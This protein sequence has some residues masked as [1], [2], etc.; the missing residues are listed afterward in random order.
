VTAPTGA[1][2][3]PADA[4][5]PELRRE[6]ASIRAE[7]ERRFDDGEAAAVLVPELARRIDRILIG[8]W[9]LHG[10]GDGAALVAVGGYGRGELHPW[11]DID[12]L[13][14]TRAD[15][16]RAVLDRVQAFI[17]GLWDLRLEVGH[18]VRSP[19]QCAEQARADVTVATAMMESRLLA[20]S[21]KLFEQMC[22][23]ATGSAVWNSRDFLEAKL[24]EQRE[25][26]RRFD[27]TAYKVE[28]NVK[29]SPGGMRD[30]QIVAWVA[31]HHFGVSRLEDLVSR[32]FLTVGE[33][34]ALIAGRDF[35][36]Q[37]R[38]ALHVDAGRREDRLLFEHQRAL[39]SRFG[40]RDDDANLAVEQFMRRYYRTVMELSRLIEMLMELLLEAILVT[41]GETAPAI[42]NRRF[43]SVSGFLE[44]RDDAVFARQPWA[45]LELF[46]VLQQNPQLKGVRASTIRLVRDH[47]HLIDDSFR[48]DIR[49]RSLFL[50]IL[51]QPRGVTHELE[52][53]HRYGVL[54]AYLP[55]FD[56]VSGRM[57]FDLFHMY[58]V[59]EHSLR[60]VGKLRAFA[61]PAK[62]HEHPLC[63][64]IFERL[65]KPELLYI[66]G[67]FHDLAKGRGGDHSELGAGDVLAFCTDHGL[68]QYDARLAAWLVRHHLLMST[69][70]QRRD[71]TDP[72][73]V[74]EFALEVADQ[75]HL[76]YLYLLT[77]GDIRGTNPKLWNDWRASLLRDLYVATSRALRAGLEN[78]LERTQ[79]IAETQAQAELV[80]K[81]LDPT[82]PER[83]ASLWTTLGDDYFLRSSP[84]EVAWH[85]R[86]IVEAGEQGLPLVLARAGRGG[87][88]IFVYARD[89]EFLFAATCS[90]LDRLGLSI[91][92]SRII[93]ADNAMTLDSYV[94]LDLE[95]EPVREPGRL[96]AI[97]HALHQ[98]LTAPAQA[99]GETRRLL[100]RQLK[101]FSTPTDVLFSEDPRNRRTVLD[102]ITADRPG[103]L[104]RIGWTL[105]DHGV[106]LQNAK[107]STFGERAEDV[108]FVTDSA[109][110]P[111]PQA[112]LADLREALEAAIA[113]S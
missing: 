107:I 23:Q 20:G 84:D 104:A 17:A 56:R 79:L 29:E 61:I 65:P 3:A 96:A 66:A 28:P 32:D 62:A 94:V 88:E 22:N 99:R 18:S 39:A 70:S 10:V 60:V 27:G 4:T 6:A 82:L 55:V 25:R 34:Q 49:A 110:R 51:R 81:L 109:N 12:L 21:A 44:V 97:E 11:S 52:R 41:P 103:L 50:E 30:L 76:D 9:G 54:G 42:I 59:D 92:D 67:L 100:R 8:A 91:V 102:V 87:T 106:R 112:R 36:W 111:L 73:V 113:P 83:A 89:Q 35:L 19:A 77:V 37:V 85:S 14:I 7:L 24:A 75:T 43:Q 58:T 64:A 53:M 46:L 33:L 93:T 47:C 80:L 15:P 78:P 86:G 26:Y 40:Y 13:V 2:A 16:G 74:H 63:A 69:T 95:G 48:A 71:I 101:A 5:A 57:Q 1:G 90:L 68:G 108:F 31:K 105:A 38:F 72:D 98:G 45:L